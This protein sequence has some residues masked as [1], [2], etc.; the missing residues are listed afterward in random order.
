MN[1]AEI[2]ELEYVN[3][4]GIGVSL[5][6]QGCHFHCH[7]CFNS[8]TWDFSGGEPY[9]QETEEKL[10]DLLRRPYIKRFSILGGEPLAPENVSDVCNLILF[11]RV[12][13]PDIKIWLYTGYT[14]ESIIG[15]YLADQDNDV[16]I[17]ERMTAL[18]N[19]DYLV[20]GRYVHEK[21][22]IT[23]PFRGSTNQ[24]IIDVQVSLDKGV[25]VEK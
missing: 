6:V 14:Y 5:F 7:N 25:V 21:R 1:Y 20:D 22:D 19:V 15:D 9:T 4:E 11:V 13:Y 3:G 8:E 23:L 24:R 16:E 2:D 12:Y 17:V 18:C 10:L